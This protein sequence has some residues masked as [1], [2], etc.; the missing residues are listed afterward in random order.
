MRLSSI[1]DIHHIESRLGIGVVYKYVGSLK[2]KDS[3]LV[4]KSYLPEADNIYTITPN[5]TPW[6]DIIPFFSAKKEDK[7]PFVDQRRKEVSLLKQWWLERIHHSSYPL[8]E[9]MTLLWHNHFTS[10]IAQVQWPQLMYQQNQLLRKHALGSFADLLK[11]IYK[12]PAMLIYLNGQQ[13]S[14]IKPNENFARELL[15]LFTLGVGYYTEQDIISAARAF[16]GW[17][18]NYKEGAVVF[19]EKRHDDGIKTF[20]GKTGRYDAD[21]IIAIILEQPRLAEFITEK[22]WYNFISSKTPDNEYIQFWAK[23]FKDSNYNITVLLNSIIQ[24]DVFWSSENRSTLIKSPIEFTI[25]LIRE[26]DLEH[27]N[28]YSRLATI[29]QQLGQDLFSPPDVKGWRGGNQWINSSSLALRHDFAAKIL[30]EHKNNSYGLDFIDRLESAEIQQLLLG[31]DEPKIGA[32]DS[33]NMSLLEIVIQHPS[34]Q[35]R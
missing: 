20:L 4:L 14:K 18:Y 28:A 12:D 35:L 33:N 2:Y 30:K 6:G 17:S 21:D 15:E 16:T 24:S 7:K 26:L 13:S 22:F 3:S 19:N 32:T 1:K 23:I 29:N 25:G 9:R 10:S 11:G 31:F 34:Y 8:Q 5:L 27:F